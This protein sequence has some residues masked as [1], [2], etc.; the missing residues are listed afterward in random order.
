MYTMCNSVN[1][2]H[3]YVQKIIVKDSYRECKVNDFDL[4]NQA[5]VYYV[6]NIGYQ[7]HWKKTRFKEE[8][9]C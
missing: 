8:Q 1:Q 3:S 2:R 6:S 5:V 4:L 7:N 9:V